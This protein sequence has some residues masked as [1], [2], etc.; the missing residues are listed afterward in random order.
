LVEAKNVIVRVESLNERV[1][2]IVHSYF[3]YMVLM[4]LIFSV[5]VLSGRNGTMGT[6]S[7]M[8]VETRNHFTKFVAVGTIGSA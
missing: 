4:A 7:T 8:A 1:H 2:Q 6:I 3:L 5:D